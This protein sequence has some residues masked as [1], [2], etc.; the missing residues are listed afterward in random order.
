MYDGCAY[1]YRIYTYKLRYFITWGYLVWLTNMYCCHGNGCGGAQNFTVLCTSNGL[2]HV[3]I[4]SGHLTNT[5]GLM[6]GCMCVQSMML[7][8]KYTV[9]QIQPKGYFIA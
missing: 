3:I 5:Q 4:A 6:M 9:M 2:K 7:K 8:E 1:Y